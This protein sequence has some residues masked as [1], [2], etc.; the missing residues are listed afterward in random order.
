MIYFLSWKSCTII[1]LT[2][3][4]LSVGYVFQDGRQRKM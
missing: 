1:V 2:T 4:K 3:C